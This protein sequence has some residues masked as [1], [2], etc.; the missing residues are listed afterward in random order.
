MFEPIKRAFTNSRIERELER[1]R[2]EHANNQEAKAGL[3]PA[4]NERSKDARENSE[5]GKVRR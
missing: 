5:S 2:H 1:E 4:D 3:A